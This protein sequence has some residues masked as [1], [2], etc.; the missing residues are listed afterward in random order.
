MAIASS[1]ASKRISS[2]DQKGKVGKGVK[3]KE[4]KSRKRSE[5]GCDLPAKRLKAPGVRVIHGRIYDSEHGKTC[6]QVGYIYVTPRSIVISVTHIIDGR[7]GDCMVFHATGLFGCESDTE[8]GQKKWQFWRTGAVRSAEASAIAF[9]SS[10]LETTA[11][12]RKKR[13]HQPTGILVHTAKATG[14]SSVSQLLHIQGSENPDVVKNVKAEPIKRGKENSFSGNSNLNSHSIASPSIPNGQKLKTMKQTGLKEKENG[15]RGDGILLHETSHV[16]PQISNERLKKKNHRKQTDGVL[17]KG[18]LKDTKEDNQHDEILLKETNT[19]N[20]PVSKQG[21]PRMQDSMG[22]N[23]I[24]M[25]EVKTNRD[26]IVPEDEKNLEVSVSDEV[27]SNLIARK[28]SKDH[29]DSRPYKVEADALKLQ[30]NDIDDDIP[31][32]QGAEVTTVAGVDLPAEDVGYAL[33]FLEFCTAFNEILDLKQ[34][35]P[36]KLLRELMHGRRG[37]PGKYSPAVQFHIQ[38]L[39]M[40]LEDLG[41]DSEAITQK[42][43]KNSWLHALQKCASRS[44]SVLKKLKL[45]LFGQEADDYDILDS[46]QRLRLLEKQLKQKMLDEVA[47]AIIAKNGALLSISEHEAVVLQIKTEVA[48]ARAEIMESQDM[49][50]NGIKGSAAFRTEPILL[51]R[52]GRT[53]WKLNEYS[54]NSNVLLQ[55]VGTSDAVESSEK[56]FTFDVEQEREI[57][58]YISSRRRSKGSFIKNGKHRNI[59]ILPL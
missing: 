57:E 52:N 56:W 39:S 47:K 27:S 10:V 30:N 40:I 25:K 43:G 33:Q 49:V 9:I 7:R 31:L 53:Y 34:G 29:K 24:S 19:R 50:P 32:P 18:G 4:E 37:R 16:K 59:E 54:D 5:D 12:F 41:E 26:V 15:N 46:S 35:E 1:S 6:H 8:R 58:E 11:F 28:K 48:Q 38:L 42:N 44:Q 2:P 17:A 36:S 13:G 21:S 14:F 23:V 55:D 22:H 20:P 51:D 45:D 3:T